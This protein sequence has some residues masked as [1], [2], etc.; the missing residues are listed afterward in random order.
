MAY[1][2]AEYWY[3]V[4]KAVADFGD[5]M[6]D[7]AK[8]KAELAAMS[9][10]VKSE[11]A[12]EVAGATKAA[13]ARQADI[14]AIKS[15]SQEL[16]RLADSA[17]ATNVQLLYGG[18]NDMQQHLSDLDRELNYQT[19]LNRQEW[20]G[21]STVQQAMAYR[22]QMLQQQ[23]L[24]NRAEFAGYLTADQYLSYMTKRTMAASLET[25]AVRARASAVSEEAQ[26]MLAYDNA[27]AGT[28]ASVGQLGEGTSAYAAAL[29]GA[30]PLVVTRAEF[31]DAGAL[32]AIAAYQA[33][34]AGIPGSETTISSSV[35]SPLPVPAEPV[36]TGADLAAIEALGEALDELAVR[37][38]ALEAS[39]GTASFKP[40]EGDEAAW[41]ALVDRV[42]AAYD[43][44]EAADAEAK[45]TAGD[46]APN[47]A[48][49]AAWEQL[50]LGVG[51]FS[52]AVSEAAAA[53]GW[54]QLAL[55]VEYFSGKVEAIPGR[56]TSTAVFDDAA[57]EKELAAW[58]DDLE[59]G[60]QVRYVVEESV[61]VKLPAGGGGAAGGGGGGGPPAAASMGDDAGG[62]G[63]GVV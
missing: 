10:A 19:L 50:T 60:R 22:Q 17:K 36:P 58:L 44:M 56:A 1:E 24:E 15:E 39:A 52:Q 3:V 34:L 6:R 59:A 57:A 42:G 51:S 30:P 16:S 14:T 33:V 26:A 31:D 37:E 35:S 25:A 27:V 4:Y 5:L 38:S 7:A 61:G 62:G 23:L 43:A 55:D 20:L 12:A 53:P 40:G 9:D 41:Q 54:D 63:G 8:A 32:D 21:F 48:D 11:S 18:R 13:E 49:T 2:G 29:A 28:H 46:F 47:P 45:R